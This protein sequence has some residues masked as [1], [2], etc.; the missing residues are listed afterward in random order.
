VLALASYRPAVSMP[1][2]ALVWCGLWTMIYAK[3]HQE[4][5]EAAE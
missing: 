3:R 2:A 5:G 4:P 1:L